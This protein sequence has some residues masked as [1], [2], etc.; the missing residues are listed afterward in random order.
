MA[1]R[2][3]LGSGSNKKSGF[4]NVDKS[5]EA[6]PDVL[7]DIN[8]LPWK[9]AKSNSADRIECDNF[10]EH[11]ERYRWIKMVRECHRVLKP[12]GILWIKAP[13]MT[14]DNL[15]AVCSDPTHVNWFTMHTFDYYNYRHLRWLH[16]GKYYVIPP[17]EVAIP[18]TRKGRF[19]TVHLR[20]IKE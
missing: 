13:V 9:W 3:N 7:A 10:P 15:D 17:F 1:L 16:Y 6:K 19:V 20:A 2:Y 11:I 14:A 12:R 4:V 18:A 8:V 5:K